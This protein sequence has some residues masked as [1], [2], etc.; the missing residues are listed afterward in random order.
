MPPLMSAL[1][2]ATPPGALAL[3]SAIAATVIELLLVKLTLA[4]AL[5][6]LAA[7]SAC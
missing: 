6:D 5:P 1:A 7:A 4:L 3:A 2:V